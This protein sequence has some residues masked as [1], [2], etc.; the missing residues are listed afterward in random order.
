MDDRA[1]TVTVCEWLAAANVGVWRPDGPTYTGS[2]TG[3]FYGPLEPAPDRAIGVTV[4]GTDDDVAVGTSTRW[5]QVRVRGARGRPEGADELAGVIFTALHRVHARAG[6]SRARRISSAHLGPDDN[7]R[8]ERTDN[9][10]ITLS[11]A[12]GGTP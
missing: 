4:Y 8:Q 10:E 5:V 11:P 2:E 1:L 7:G 6:V 12:P 3:I 9:Y